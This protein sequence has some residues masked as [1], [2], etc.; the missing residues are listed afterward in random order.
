MNKSKYNRKI[1]GNPIHRLQKGLTMKE[2]YKLYKKINR[3]ANICFL[4]KINGVL[5]KTVPYDCKILDYNYD[6]SKSEH[7][8]L[9]MFPESY[10]LFS[11]NNVKYTW[12]VSIG[13]IE[14]TQYELFFKTDEH[15]HDVLIFKDNTICLPI[16]DLKTYD[17]EID[18]N[19]IKKYHHV[20]DSVSKMII[21]VL[22]K[23][24]KLLIKY[25]K[26]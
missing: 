17:V 12:N 14:T 21:C 9:T 24:I 6:V 13:G 8:N 18:V 10:I 19:K 25:N 16:K 5:A 1:I 11:L 2:Y 4:N 7:V 26:Y 15:G 3:D 22:T 23:I 20:E